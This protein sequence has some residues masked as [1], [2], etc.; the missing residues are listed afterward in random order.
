MGGS[1]L[2]RAELPTI[3]PRCSQ[4]YPFGAIVS[5]VVLKIFFLIILTEY[6]RSATP[7]ALSVES[8]L[9]YGV[10]IVYLYFMKFLIS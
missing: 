4:Y 7:L 1:I 8:A 10:G 6:N 2:W 3:H 5:F 9:C